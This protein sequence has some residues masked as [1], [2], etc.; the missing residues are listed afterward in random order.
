MLTKVGLNMS[1]KFYYYNNVQYFSPKSQGF[2]LITS[3][4]LNQLHSPTPQP[5]EFGTADQLL[6]YEVVNIK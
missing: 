4:C 3:G 1:K 6:T 5:T 2:T